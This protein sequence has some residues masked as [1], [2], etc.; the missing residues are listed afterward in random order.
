MTKLKSNT[1]QFFSTLAFIIE[2]PYIYLLIIFVAVRLSTV[3]LELLTGKKKC[4]TNAKVIII[5]VL[6]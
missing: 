1:D 6:K 2:N 4:F 3:F 5:K